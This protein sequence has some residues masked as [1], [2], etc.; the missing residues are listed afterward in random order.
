MF[1]TVHTERG[2]WTQRGECWMSGPAYSRICRRGLKRWRA[3]ARRHL[4]A[5]FFPFFLFSFFLFPLSFFAIGDKQQIAGTDP[6]EC[7]PL[8][9][10]P[11]THRCILVDPGTPHTLLPQR[12]P[13]MPVASPRAGGAAELAAAQKNIWVAAGEGDM[14]RVRHLID[15]EG[16]SWREGQGLV[17]PPCAPSLSFFVG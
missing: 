10:R 7:A 14:E 17:G 3:A 1:C 8:G 4:A 13:S 12:A 16:A 2:A 15:N 9:L 6:Q 11:H 5:P